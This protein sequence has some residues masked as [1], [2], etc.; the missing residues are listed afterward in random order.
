MKIITGDWHIHDDSKYAKLAKFVAYIGRVKPKTL[1]LSEVSDLWQADRET[2]EATRSWQMLRGLCVRR[3]LMG[4][5]T[6]WVL[7]NH[8]F[9]V[10]DDML[11]LAKT[12]HEYRDGGL[13][14]LHG[15][16]FDSWWRVFTPVMVPLSIKFP[17]LCRRLFTLRRMTIGRMSSGRDRDVAVGKAHARAQQYAEHHKV[18][19]VFGHTH[20]PESIWHSA[21]NWGDMVENF[22]W[23]EVAGDNIRVRQLDEIE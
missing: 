11:P 22:T 23:V 16:Q 2:I 19:L 13:L 10:G 9:G 14:V 17:T 20:A 4:L 5:E 8:E 18:D 7:G 1:I 6:Y 15:W 3:H 12:C 21:S